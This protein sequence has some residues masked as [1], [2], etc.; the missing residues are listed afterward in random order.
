MYTHRNIDRSNSSLKNGNYKNLIPSSA[1][2][3]I[4]ERS[5][6]SNR[7]VNMNQL[8]GI[9][10]HQRAQSRENCIEISPFSTIHTKPN[11]PHMTGTISDNPNLGS[12]SNANFNTNTQSQTLHKNIISRVGLVSRGESDILPSNVSTNINTLLSRNKKNHT[13]LSDHSSQYE[14]FSA[15]KAEDKSTVTNIR[16]SFFIALCNSAIQIF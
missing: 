7:N 13:H 12:N 6:T 16:F 9:V 11:M 3:G 8:S 4:G 10:P 5:K 2:V 14:I 15:S 1:V